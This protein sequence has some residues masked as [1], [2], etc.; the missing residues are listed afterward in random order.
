MGVQAL[1]SIQ[2]N[3]RRG[4]VLTGLPTRGGAAAQQANVAIWIGHLA[5]RG[6]GKGLRI[7]WAEDDT[8]EVV[9]FVRGPWEEAALVL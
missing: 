2:R 6:P 1:D 7:L 4:S 5:R 9:S 3:R 8:I